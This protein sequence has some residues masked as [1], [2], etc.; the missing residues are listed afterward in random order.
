MPDSLPSWIVSGIRRRRMHRCIAE[1][2]EHPSRTCKALAYQYSL[3][4]VEDKAI[5]YLLRADKARP[6]AN[7]EAI[8]FYTMLSS[9]PANG[10]QAF[11]VGALGY[12]L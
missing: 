5:F 7:D 1:S 8:K 6:V 11:V 4:E 3:A 9:L 10:Y 2:T 12:Q